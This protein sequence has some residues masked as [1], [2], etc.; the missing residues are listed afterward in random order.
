MISS[1][2]HN[3]KY[4]ALD[5]KNFFNHINICLNAVIILREDLLP[6]YHYIKRQSEYEEYFIPD[7]D[8]PSY[9]WNWTLMISGN[10]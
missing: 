6:D 4:T 2:R 3:S 10:D 1:S 7:L 5:S 8:H 9:Y